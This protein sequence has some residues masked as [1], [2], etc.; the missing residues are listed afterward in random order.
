MKVVGWLRL[1]A[2]ATLVSAA[3]GTVKPPVAANPTASPGVTPIASGDPS[4]AVTLSPT[5]KA[6]SRST[7]KATPTASPLGHCPAAPAAG[8]PSANRNLAL[9]SLRG[10]DGFVVR[11]LTDISHPKTISNLGIGISPPSF[12]SASAIAY[13]AEAGLVC[14]PLT[15][16][17]ETTVANKQAFIDS[18]AWSPDGKSVVY[19]TANASGGVAHQMSEGRDQILA[20]VFKPT[21]GVG[22]ETQF[23][24]LTDSADFALSYSPDGSTISMVE[25]I[26]SVSTF[27]LWSSSG[28]V[29]N[30]SDSKLRSMSTWSGSSFYFEGNGVE[31]WSAG[32]TS[33]FLPG[34]F[35]IR[36]KASPAGGQIV[37][38][39]RDAQGWHHTFVVDIATKQVRELKKGRSEPA[40]LT[41][42]YV[43]YRGERQCVAADQCPSG[44]TVVASGKTYIYDLLAGT[45]T[46]SVITSVFDVWPHAA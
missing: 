8:S 15:G 42:R 18:F 25:N 30:N 6:T 40:F 34:V 20:G 46:E 27:R 35:W 12:V 19:L 33:P 4:P 32:V 13:G 31:V 5:P 38:A 41:S 21:P 37:Y 29:L 44:W 1:L 9:V 28:K 22:C 16:S 45:E 39:T 43:W 10:S 2:I 14:V 26:L 7:P 11:D 36:P 23:C 3:C 24:S 17:P